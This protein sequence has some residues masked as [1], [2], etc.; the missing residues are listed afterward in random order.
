MS[1]DDWALIRAEYEAG[2]SLRKLALKYGVSKSLI[3]KKKFAEQWTEHVD[4]VGN[5]DREKIQAPFVKDLSSQKSLTTKDRQRLFLEAFSKHANV[6][7][8]ARAADISRQIVYHWLEHDE[9]FS[10]A[11]NQAKEDAK[12][13]LRAE[14]VRRGVDGWE[15]N[16]YYM[17]LFQGT[18]RKYSDTL[19]IFHSKALMQEYREKQSID[20]TTHP[21]VSG[22]KEL[23][24]QRL[25]RLEGSEA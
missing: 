25:A 2:A 21:D 16:V 20:I 5:V 11:Y 17:G 24:M 23:L 18:V 10:F 13:V 12:D 7:V 14:I 6:L 3:G 15:E 1:T 9:A 22:A 19:L 4:K 8:A